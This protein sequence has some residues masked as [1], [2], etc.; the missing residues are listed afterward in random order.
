MYLVWDETTAI[1]ID[2]RFCHS[3]HVHE[4]AMDTDANDIISRTINNTQKVDN[5]INISE[6]GRILN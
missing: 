3:V 5:N 1:Q 2:W 6:T 4:S